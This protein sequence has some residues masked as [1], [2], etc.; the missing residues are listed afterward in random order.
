MLE[1]EN[2]TT[3]V[4]FILAAAGSAVGLGNIWR[5]PYV[6][7]E[8]GGAVFLIIYLLAI[9]F[10][11]YPVMVTEISIGRKSN[12][13]P[14][15]AFKS[16]APDTPWWLV[17]S[18]GVFTGFV[19]LSFY[20][21]VAGW[22]MA[23][24]FKAIGGF[25]PE[26]EFG[27]LFG[28]HIASAGTTLIW[29]AV[30]MALTI[31]VI[32]GGVVGGIQKVV[33]ILMPVLF[34]LLVVLGIRSLTLEGA[35]E[36]VLFFLR[37]SLGDFTL[38]SL[39][40]AIGQAF[41]TLSLGMGAMITYGSYLSEKDSITDSAGYIVGLD[42]L[43]AIISGFAIFPAV[44]ALGMA[45]TE[46]PGLAFVT[47]PGVFAEMPLGSFFGFLFFLLLSIAALTSA[48]SLLEVVTAWLI[49]EK[50][51][52]RKKAATVLGIIIFLTGIPPLLG[53]SAWSGFSFL[54]MDILD[55]YDWFA[56]DLFLPFGGM[57]TL[58]FAGHIWGARNTSSE[59]NKVQ[60]K[61]NV[62]NLFGILIKYILPLVI[63]IIL[64]LNIY[65]TIF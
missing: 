38:D 22:S 10:I 15:G 40:A 45:P 31:G 47:L 56:S 55:T 35:G 18:L 30:F 23:Y 43:I 29:H 34:I 58:I 48:I 32:A 13:N 53:Y 49:D 41:F 59:A 1:R 17:G 25:T 27:A 21:V 3:R 33:K 64:V 12:R 36:G 26:M 16:L 54:E 39:G 61:I 60:S 2:W 37:P 5:F 8:N 65:E 52:P 50:N 62:G 63:F 9:I 19:I 20:S 6:A 7:G 14:V 44:F 51:W 4:G 28:D 46:G 24:I 11:G 57:L 42:T